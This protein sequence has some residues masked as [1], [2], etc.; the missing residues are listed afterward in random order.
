MNSSALIANLVVR[1]TS[2]A[3]HCSIPG[4]ICDTSHRLWVR[5]NRHAGIAGSGFGRL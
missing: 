2:L 4:K 1:T 3:H 5:R